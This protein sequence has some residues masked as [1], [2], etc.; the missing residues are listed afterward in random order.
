MR[1]SEIWECYPK[2]RWYAAYSC[3]F[4][5]TYWVDDIPNW[6]QT[7]FDPYKYDISLQFEPG[8]FERCFIIVSFVV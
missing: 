8:P 2:P 5:P 1:V 3:C 7:S 4:F 6:L